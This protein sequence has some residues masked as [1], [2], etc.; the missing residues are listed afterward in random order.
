MPPS[1]S[2]APRQS[3]IPS[4]GERDAIRRPGRKSG[5]KDRA[6]ARQR[7]P[8][9]GDAPGND[10][11]FGGIHSGSLSSWRR[12]QGAKGAMGTEGATTSRTLCTL[13]TRCTPGLPDNHWSGRSSYTRRLPRNLASAGRVRS[14]REV[15]RQR[16]NLLGLEAQVWH[17]EADVVTLWHRGRVGEQLLHE[18]LVVLV[19]ADVDG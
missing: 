3:A 11:S 2:V 12:K 6:G 5:A 8:N 16:R 19:V 18:F 4:L 13:R 15:G 1:W 17:L 9:P 7:G 10:R 14:R